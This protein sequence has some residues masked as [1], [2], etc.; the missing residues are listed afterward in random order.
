MAYVRFA[1]QH[2]AYFEVM[3]R[4]DLYHADD[5]INPNGADH[6]PAQLTRSIAGYLFQSSGGSEASAGESSTAPTY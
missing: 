5:A 3:F 2:R 6:D 4:P 1:V